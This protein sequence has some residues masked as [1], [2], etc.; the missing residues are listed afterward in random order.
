MLVRLL[1]IGSGKKV[2]SVILLGV[3]SHPCPFAVARLLFNTV[4]WF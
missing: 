3:V 4:L 1:T 2:S